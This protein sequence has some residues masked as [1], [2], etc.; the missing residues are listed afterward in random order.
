[1]SSV[2]E[3]QHAR[4]NIYKKKKTVKRFYIQ[5]ARKYAKSKTTC[6]KFYIQKSG[7][8]TFRDFPW[9]FWIY[10]LYTKNMKLWV[11]WSFYIQN[12]ETSQKRGQFASCFY[13]QKSIH[14]ALRNFSLNLFIYIQIIIHL[15]LH[16]SMQKTM[17]FPLR[18]YKQNSWNFELHF[19][20]PFKMYF[21]LRFYI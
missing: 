8:L 6:A 9:K 19:Y 15:A 11:T 20:M 7:H 5:K 12:P 3:R 18:Y 2:S 21:A 13:I 4:F 10:S 14:S 1:M 17:H 16:F